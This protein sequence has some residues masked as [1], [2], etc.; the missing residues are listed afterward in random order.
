MSVTSRDFVKALAANS[1]SDAFGTIIPAVTAPVS[2]A[3]LGVFDLFSQEL[4]W[5]GANLVPSHLQLMPYATAANNV[6][7]GVRA[8]GWN[9]VSGSELYVPQLLVNLAVTAGNIA[10]TVLGTNHFMSDTIAV[11]DGAADNAE[12][13]SLISD[14]LDL[15]SSIIVHTRGCRWIGV[16]FNVGATTETATAAN[17]LVRPMDI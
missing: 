5:G 15:G 14:V 6:T 1:T 9:K 13:L 7:F 11:T 10:A 12:W 17:C 16:E 8:W 3:N 4:G 2:A